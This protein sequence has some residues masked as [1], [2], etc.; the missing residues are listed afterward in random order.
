MDH[1]V[2]IVYQIQGSFARQAVSHTAKSKMTFS[3]VYFTT[4]YYY[5]LCLFVLNIMQN[6][7]KMR[8]EIFELM[9]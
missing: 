6:E 9:S 5:N 3:N 4:H 7:L 2:S 1:P 8:F